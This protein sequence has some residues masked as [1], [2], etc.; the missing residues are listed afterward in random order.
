MYIHTHIHTYIHMSNAPMY[1]TSIRIH[2]CAHAVAAQTPLA[3]NDNDN[4]NNG[5]RYVDTV[6]ICKP[7]TKGLSNT[8]TTTTASTTK[9][10]KHNQRTITHNQP[11]QH[12]KKHLR[13]KNL[14]LSVRPLSKEKAVTASK[15]LHPLYAP[16]P[17]HC[18]QTPTPMPVPDHTCRC[19]HDEQQQEQ[20]KQKQ[21]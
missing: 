9:Q 8:T 10:S 2:A 12:P 21:K 4:R 11:K 6:R 19:M 13:A 3:N 16:T 17:P 5:D 14:S 18:A 20:Q 15:N 1:C 7:T